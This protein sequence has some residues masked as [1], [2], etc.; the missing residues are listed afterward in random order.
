MPTLHQLVSSV[1]PGD[2]T[3]THTFLVRD[4]LRAAGFESEI[5]VLAAHRRLEGEVQ[6]Y[7]RLLGPSRSD[8]HLLYQFSAWSP[9]ADWLFGRQEQLALNYHNI[10]PASFYRGWDLGMVRAL[11]DGRVQLEQLAR[12]RPAGIAVSRYNAEDLRA[13]GLLDVS[14]VPVLMDLDVTAHGEPDPD[15]AA[16]LAA[17]R[18][19]S[20]DA[21]VWLFVGALAPHKAQHELVQS[22]AVYR[23]AFG[24]EARL[25][26]VGKPASPPYAAAL[27]AYVHELG[28]DDHVVITG[29]VTD[30]QRAAYEADADVFVCLSRHEG[31]CVPV[32]EAMARAT[33]VIARS[34]GA[35]AETVGSGAL[36]VDAGAGAS[37]TAGALWRVAHD[38]PLRGALAQAGLARAAEFSLARTSAAMVACLRRFVSGGGGEAS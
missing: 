9:L 26:L 19:I 20:G 29:E 11:D 15:T 17:R 30:A 38:A 16:Q 21:P 27:V 6:M 34:A 32:V 25:H 23:R 36:V 18:D 4:A 24:A 5:F 13:S 3:T 31:F 14:V 22:L 33:P 28:L 35:V 10:T 37:D 12:R 1:A 2:A 7:H 8:G